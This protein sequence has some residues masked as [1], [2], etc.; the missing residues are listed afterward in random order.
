[1]NNVKDSLLRKK[2]TDGKICHLFASASSDIYIRS[3]VRNLVLAIRTIII[4]SY[5]SFGLHFED[6]TA[7]NYQMVSDIT[8]EYLFAEPDLFNLLCLYINQQHIL[9]FY[10]V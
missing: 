9:I 8:S 1:M 2:I 10:Y 7:N 6:T 5:S 3:Q 4:L